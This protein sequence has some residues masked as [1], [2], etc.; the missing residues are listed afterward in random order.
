[1][2]SSGDVNVF[3]WNREWSFS[4]RV[5]LDPGFN[6]MAV[7]EAS[8]HGK[9]IINC[10]TGIGNESWGGG[11]DPSDSPRKPT[12]LSPR[13]GRS[14]IKVDVLSS[15]SPPGSLIRPSTA[16]NIY[17]SIFIGK[18]HILCIESFR[19]DF[20]CVHR[21]QFVNVCNQYVTLPNSSPRTERIRGTIQV[22][23]FFPNWKILDW[24][25]A[26]IGWYSTNDQME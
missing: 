14:C 22:R 13:I 18:Y 3:Q 1:M 24:S 10:F 11:R 19:V 4:R 2:C 23:L 12:W 20:R 9:E 26:V 25:F 6:V 16:G 7:Y 15:W 8:W 5:K 21:F 17:F